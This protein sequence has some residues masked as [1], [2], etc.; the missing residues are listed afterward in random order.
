MNI[1]R[2]FT[3]VVAMTCAALL[4]PAGISSSASS[5]ASSRVSIA[6]LDRPAAFGD[7]LPPAVAKLV[8][9][10]EVDASTTGLGA[11]RG[12]VQYFVA[13]RARG[14]CLIRIDDPVGPVFTTTCASS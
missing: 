1:Q 14:L 12:S 5:S 7:Q 6:L 2:T 8:D 11:T 9:V 10:K 13:Q 4:L 3:L